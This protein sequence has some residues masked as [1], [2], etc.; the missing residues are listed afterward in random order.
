MS[1]DAQRTI[2]LDA[3]QRELNKHL[4]DF[5]AKFGVWE[6]TRF[7]L[8]QLAGRQRKDG[9]ITKADY[10]GENYRITVKLLKK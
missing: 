9:H 8:N 5:A 2:E 7:L 4:D 1:T 6:L 10:A 3:N